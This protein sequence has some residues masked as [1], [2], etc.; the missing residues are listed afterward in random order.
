MSGRP[1]GF[2]E[3]TTLHATRRPSIAEV[4]WAAGFIEGE[5][6]F[7]RHQSVVNATQ[8]NKEPVERLQQIFG[9][10]VRPTYAG[11]RQYWRWGVCG[12]RARG[13]AMTVYAFLSAKR[14]AQARATLHVI[15]K[16]G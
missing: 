5:G 6:T 7:S 10:S 9:G 2:E 13:V 14:K 12:G 8:L 16:A 1:Y 15:K 4:G 3:R 11:G